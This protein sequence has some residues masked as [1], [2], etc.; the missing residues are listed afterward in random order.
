MPMTQYIKIKLDFILERR[1]RSIVDT[2]NDLT[3]IAYTL[4]ANQVIEKSGTGGSNMSNLRIIHSH[5]TEVLYGFYAQ[6]PLARDV[7]TFV[8]PNDYGMIERLPKFIRDAQP[9]AIDP[10]RFDPVTR[11]VSAEIMFATSH[12]FSEQAID[13]AMAHY[14]DAIE[15]SIGADV[16]WHLVFDLKAG[17]LHTEKH[18]W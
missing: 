13:N 9:G 12:I 17:A 15:L 6:A 4:D 18:S 3:H 11:T 1:N 8:R 7:M 5:E 14:R 16:G 10:P 2:Y